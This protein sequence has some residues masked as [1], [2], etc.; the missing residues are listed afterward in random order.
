MPIGEILDRYSI[1]ILKKERA[2]P[3]KLRGKIVG[4]GNT[5]DSYGE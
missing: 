3:K 2:K 5:M 4:V 1:A